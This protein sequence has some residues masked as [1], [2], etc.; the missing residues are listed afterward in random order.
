MTDTPSSSY[1][2]D[3]V[4]GDH[5]LVP[6]PAYLRK[7]PRLTPVD[8]IRISRGVAAGIGYIH[9]NDIK[10]TVVNLKSVLVEVDVNVRHEMSTYFISSDLLRSLLSGII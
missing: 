1:V 2:A 9:N 10:N 3:P 5:V 4:A 8:A 7:H 6:L